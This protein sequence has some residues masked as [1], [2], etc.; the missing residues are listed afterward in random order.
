MQPA[1]PSNKLQKIF[2]ICLVLMIFFFC[3]NMILGGSL[4]T[5]T[6]D[7]AVLTQF[8]S[9]AELVKPNFE[10]SLNLYTKGTEESIAYVDTL[11]PDTESEYIQFISS[12]EAI[13]QKLSLNFDL[14]SLGVAKEKD[15]TLD[16]RIRFFGGQVELLSFLEELEALPYYIRVDGVQYESL[17]RLSRTNVD[18]PTNLALT[19]KLYVK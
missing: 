12:I 10:Q 15:E 3:M 17:A 4:K 18:T 1:A 6:R 5:L 16:Y 13:G 2:N 19:I 7:I 8:L 14:E 9:N 11:R